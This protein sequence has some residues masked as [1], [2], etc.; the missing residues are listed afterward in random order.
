M[1]EVKVKLGP[2]GQVVIPKLFRDEFK[3]EPGKEVVLKEEKEGVLIKRG[4]DTVK[5]FKKLAEEATKLRK[6]KKLKFDVHAI[7]EQYEKRARKA[8]I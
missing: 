6:G 5:A 2:K 3:L 1:V 4:E 7:H 8:G